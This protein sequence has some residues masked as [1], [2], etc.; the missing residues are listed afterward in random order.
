MKPENRQKFLLIAAACIVGIYLL[1]LVVIGPLT[2]SWKER[3]DE[4][5][6]L[7]ADIEKG[8]G[9]I[10]NEQSIRRRWNEMRKNT[11]AFDVSAAEQELLGAFNNWAQNSRVTVTSTKPQWKR[12][13]LSEDYSLLECRVD[14]MG[15]MS[16]VARFLYEVEHSP[17][18]LKIESVELSTRDNSGGQIALGLLVSGLRLKPMEGK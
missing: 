3:S 11:L 6:K 13:T 9:V 8:K 4:I 18:A 1:D 2:A 10:Q 16:T 14:A 12:G 7:K 17:M 5:A 15:S